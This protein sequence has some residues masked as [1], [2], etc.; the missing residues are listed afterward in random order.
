MNFIYSKND[1]HVRT[2]RLVNSV[3]KEELK[4]IHAFSQKTFTNEQWPVPDAKTILS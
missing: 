1:Y 3:L 4:N 2:Y